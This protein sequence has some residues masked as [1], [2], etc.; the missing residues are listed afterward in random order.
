MDRDRSQAAS[1]P[2]VD[3]AVAA[4]DVQRIGDRGP[5]VGPHKHVA[6]GDV[7]YFVGRLVRLAG[8]GD[9][10]IC[11]GEDLRRERGLVTSRVLAGTCWRVGVSWGSGLG[12]GTGSHDT[13]PSAATAKRVYRFAVF[14]FVLKR[15]GMTR[16]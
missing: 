15:P 1:S 11:R 5:H 16:R 6:V 9:R 10:A 13:L 7:E 12:L 8:P 3:A 4:G 2:A 14:S